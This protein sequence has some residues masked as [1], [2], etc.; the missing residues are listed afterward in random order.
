[1]FPIQS[2]PHTWNW[3]FCFFSRASIH[4]IHSQLFA[5]F[6]LPNKQTSGAAPWISLFLRVFFP[7]LTCYLFNWEE[8]DSVLVPRCDN[9]RAERNWYP[10][11]RAGISRIK[12]RSYLTSPQLLLTDRFTAPQP[13]DWFSSCKQARKRVGALLVKNRSFENMLFMGRF[14]VSAGRPGEFG[15]SY[16]VYTCK[17]LGLILASLTTRINPLARRQIQKPVLTTAF[18]ATFCIAISLR[19]MSIKSIVLNPDL[20]HSQVRKSKH[21]PPVRLNRSCQEKQTPNA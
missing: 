18:R 8:I 15:T 11:D 4:P 14:V 10:T 19:V 1:M 20:I 9:C 3:A 13:R 16:Q 21:Y 2:V 17:K 5:R 6:L 7:S 12:N